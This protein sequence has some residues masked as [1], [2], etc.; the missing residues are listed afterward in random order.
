MEHQTP[1]KDACEEIG[2]NEVK[3]IVR[4]TEAIDPNDPQF[5]QFL[6]RGA[7]L[8]FCGPTYLGLTLY[9]QSSGCSNQRA[10]CLSVASGSSLTATNVLNMSPSSASS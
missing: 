9:P 8:K 5:V 3:E 1:P 2:D 10:E 4:L 7:C 6:E